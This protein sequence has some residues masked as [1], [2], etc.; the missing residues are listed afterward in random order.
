M[1]LNDRLVSPSSLSKAALHLILS[2]LL[3]CCE[4]CPYSVHQHCPRHPTSGFFNPPSCNTCSTWLTGCKSLPTLL[5]RGLGSPEWLIL[6]RNRLCEVSQL[7]AS[8]SKAFLS[9]SD[10]HQNTLFYPLSLLPFC[11]WQLKLVHHNFPQPPLLL[12][13]QCFCFF[14]FLHLSTLN[15]AARIMSAIILHTFRKPK[16]QAAS[17]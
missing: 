9:S 2:T 10:H 14:M 11:L 8:T 4:I 1:Y 15:A 16:S 12:P 5:F 3:I 13:T 17:R 7:G 6:G